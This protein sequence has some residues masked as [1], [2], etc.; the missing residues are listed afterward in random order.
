MKFLLAEPKYSKLKDQ[1][2]EAL[3]ALDFDN[4]EDQANVISGLV[5]GFFRAHRNDLCYYL[6]PLV[7][8]AAVIV[9]QAPNHGDQCECPTCLLKFG[10]E[11]A[12][13]DTEEIRA[14]QAKL[15]DDLLFGR[16]NAKGKTWADVEKE[17]TPRL[18]RLLIEEHE[19]S[20]KE[21]RY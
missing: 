5:E 11:Y 15:G 17:T 18:I 14:A 6:R 10:L 21:R 13:H 16:P 12:I 8:A 9:A 3:T 7:G 1:F 4:G 2:V 20:L 19:A